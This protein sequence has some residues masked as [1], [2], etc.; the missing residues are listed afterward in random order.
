MFSAPQPA[1]LLDL[2]GKTALITG[3]SKGIG[4]ATA[5]LLGMCGAYLVLISRS[6]DVH[7]T[8]E[9]YAATHGRAPLVMQAD[10]TD[11]EA[12]AGVVGVA[13]QRFGAIDIL[14]NNAAAVSA[15]PLLETD[16]DEWVHILNTNLISVAGLC[17]QVAPGMITRKSGWI[18]N[19]ASNLG[20][21]ALANRGAYS[22]AKAGLMQLTRNLALELAPH[23][24]LV[25]TI[26]AGAIATDPTGSR[27]YDAIAQT[28]ML[29]R[30]GTPAEIANVVLFLASPLAS[31]MTGQALF[32]DGGASVWFPA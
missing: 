5:D 12:M 26:A 6:I 24:I 30:M 19:I 21:F 27:D 29:R 23:N 14:V 32:V 10:V 4:A 18:I 16:A 1:N 2:S 28:I 9:H 20:A 17:Q 22:V 15:S 3:A 11:S 25:N 13:E 8:T 7:A 31:F